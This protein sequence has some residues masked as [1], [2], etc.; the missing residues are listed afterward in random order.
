MSEDSKPLDQAEM[1][2]STPQQDVNEKQDWTMDDN[3]ETPAEFT[4]S[5]ENVLA[6][7]PVEAAEDEY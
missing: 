6:D 2:I 3:E 1:E 4:G 5:Q 7:E